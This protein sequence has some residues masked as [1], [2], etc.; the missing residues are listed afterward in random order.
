MA[1][2]LDYKKLHMSLLINTPNKTHSDNS[3]LS[4]INIPSKYLFEKSF[5]LGEISVRYEIHCMSIEHPAW[6]IYQEI[7][8]LLQSQ[9]QTI[10][11]QIAQIAFTNTSYFLVMIAVSTYE[12]RSN[13]WVQIHYFF[14]VFLL[15]AGFLFVLLSAD[16]CLPF[17]DGSVESSSITSIFFQ[18]FS[19]SSSSC[20]VCLLLCLSLSSFD[21]TCRRESKNV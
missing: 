17:D 13:L 9:V 2:H 6:E 18:I 15:L 21:L 12:V 4:M 16:L 19:V 5:L 14:P 8:F 10:V 11:S 20:D 7:S 3:C 1:H